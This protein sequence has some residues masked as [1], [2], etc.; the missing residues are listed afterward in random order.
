MARPQS[1]ERKEWELIGVQRAQEMRGALGLGRS[2]VPDIFSLLEQHE[3]LVLRYPAPGPDLN[4]FFAEYRGFL[5]IYLNSD[6]SLGRQVFSAAHE[7]CHYLYDR[8]NPKP[9]FCN[10]G[11][12]EGSDNRY[13][14]IAD[15][16]AGEFLMPK[17][18]LEF[19]F[20][21]LFGQPGIITERHVIAMQNI[22]RVSYGAM[23][24]A[25]LKAGIIK[26][27]I[28][29]RVKKLGSIENAQELRI[30][31]ARHGYSS[32]LLEPT[33]PQC[34]RSFF[35]AVSANFE[36]D[37]ISFEKLASLLAVWNRTPEEFGFER[38]EI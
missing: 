13:E 37:L 36:D 38:H 23:A 7:F 12:Y 14:V 8:Q 29:G 27:N 31:L 18:G 30:Q 9:V 6:H 2:P 15:S 4:A 24:Y 34:P 21:K 10:P 17:D 26:G 5:I 33:P 35:E 19:H 16:F 20:H 11:T 1:G 25:L 28:H 32:A 3:I 22:F